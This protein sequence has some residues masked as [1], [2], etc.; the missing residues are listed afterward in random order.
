M[1]CRDKLEGWFALL[2]S[3]AYSMASLTQLPRGRGAAGTC[4]DTDWRGQSHREEDGFAQSCLPPLMV[5]QKHRGLNGGGR[6][7]TNVALAGRPFRISAV[8]WLWHSAVRGPW[9]D[10][11]PQ[12]VRALIGH[13]ACAWQAWTRLFAPAVI[14]K[15]WWTGIGREPD[16]VLIFG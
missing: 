7:M 15:A 12:I 2:P 13:H 10:A 4:A 6:I 9:P 11:S 16:C 5:A 3:R 1:I 14:V 8:Q